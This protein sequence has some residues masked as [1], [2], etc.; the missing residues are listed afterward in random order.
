MTNQ[1]Q[2]SALAELDEWTQIEDRSQ[3]LMMSPGFLI[4]GYPPHAP[5]IGK[6]EKVPDYLGSR[7]AI[8]NLITKACVSERRTTWGLFVLH[9]M[10]VMKP[11]WFDVQRN[12][13]PLKAMAVAFVATPRQLCESLLG[14]TGKWKE[15]EEKTT[16]AAKSG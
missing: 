13:Y 9:F 2:I 14:A 1:D 8:M 7:D 11:G 16:T 6:K 4:V 5:I 3:S 10:C 12:E 15:D